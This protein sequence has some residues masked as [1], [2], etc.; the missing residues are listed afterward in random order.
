MESK[1][2]AGRPKKPEIKSEADISKDYRQRLKSQRK[3]AINIYLGDTAKATLDRICKAKNMT[4]AAAVEW[5]L[6]RAI[7]L[8]A[9]ERSNGPSLLPWQFQKGIREKLIDARNAA[10]L[11]EAAMAEKIGV[12]LN[13]YNK[14]E[15]D[16]QKV[17]EKYLQRIIQMLRLPSNFF[18]DEV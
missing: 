14:W 13:R 15:S 7:T 17:P 4:M 12:A 16:L 3:K 11:S 10:A 1:R 2:S 8:D 5:A 18:K 9:I 6:E